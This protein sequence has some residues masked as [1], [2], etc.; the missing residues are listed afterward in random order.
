MHLYLLINKQ[1]ILNTKQ[2]MQCYFIET[3]TSIEYSV[4][5]HRIPKT[6]Q[7][8][9]LSVAYVVRN[10]RV[11]Y[12][13]PEISRR[14]QFAPRCE[15]DRSGLHL[16]PGCSISPV[17]RGIPFTSLTNDYAPTID[18]SQVIA[19]FCVFI[20]LHFFFQDKKPLFQLSRL[21]RLFRKS[22]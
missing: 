17:V 2:R 15:I 6:A 9:Q 18:N 3:P 11:A 7:A 16:R 13:F 12:A 19:T 14:A 1:Y 20:F 8:M 22:F 4:F 5:A 10:F 21:S